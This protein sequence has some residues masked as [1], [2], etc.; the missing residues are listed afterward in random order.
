MQ[1]QTPVEF[2]E[3]AVLAARLDSPLAAGAWTPADPAWLL[4][5]YELADAFRRPDRFQLWLQ[6]L[7][8]RA[9]ARDI[10]LVRSSALRERLQSGLAAA[11]AV[12]LSP[13]D[14]PGLRGPAIGARLHALRLA[15][16]GQV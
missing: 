10:P 5:L 11:S 16:I 6:V 4:S 12:H 3:L 14:L 13:Q 2:R 7:T 8:A 1:L 9:H 15:A